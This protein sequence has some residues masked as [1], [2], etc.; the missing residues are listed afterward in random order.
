MSKTI[1]DNMICIRMIGKIHIGAELLYVQLFKNKTRR[2]EEVL[3]SRDYLK[4]VLYYCDLER[5]CVFI[6]KCPKLS[7]S[8]LKEGPKF[9]QSRSQG[10]KNRIENHKKF[11]V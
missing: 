3:V 2:L 1:V 11:N 5:L 7:K 10:A 6:Y 8:I 4:D 9:P